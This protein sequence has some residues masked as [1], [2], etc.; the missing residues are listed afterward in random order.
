MVV[1]E[2]PQYSEILWPVLQAV[3]ELGGSGSIGEIVETVIRRESFTDGQQ[4]VLHNDGPETE[5]GYRLAWARTYLKAMGLLT[6][7]ARGVWALTDDG[8]ALLADPSLSESQRRER[9]RAAWSAHLA[10]LRQAR[11][12]RPSRD[13]EL[14]DAAVPVQERGWKEQLLDQLMAMRPDG[15]ERLASR[16]CAK[17]TSTA[18][19][20]PARAVTEGLT[21]LAST[22]SAWS[23]SRFSSS[24]SV[25]GAAWDLAQSVTSAARW[26]AGATRACRSQPARSAPTREKKQRETGRRRSTSSTG[27]G[28]AIC[29]RSTTSE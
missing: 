6:N 13:D 2:V 28:S 17:P 19:M 4:A 15:F 26:Q 11:K 18:S 8:T 21:G 12:S 10:E 14:P 25:T 29:S 23:A 22:G 1:A 7:S 16:L 20:S 24:A 5:I 27:T 9:V 3:A